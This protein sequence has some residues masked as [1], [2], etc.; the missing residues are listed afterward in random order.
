[1]SRDFQIKQVKNTREEINQP[2]LV[3]DDFAFWQMPGPRQNQR[4]FYYRIKKVVDCSLFIF[5]SSLSYV[6]ERQSTPPGV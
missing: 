3:P 6:A 4:H 1:L 2:D 5:V